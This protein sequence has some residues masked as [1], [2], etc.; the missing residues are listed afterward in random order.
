MTLTQRIIVAGPTLTTDDQAVRNARF[1][2]DLAKLP[3]VQ[4][5]AGSNNVPGIGYNFSAD[6][7]TRP[8]PAPGDE[9][10]QYKIFIA[11]PGFF[12]VYDIRLTQGRPFTAQEAESTW[13]NQHR[14]IVNEQA[15]RQLG[16]DPRQPVAGKTIKW[17]NTAFDIVGV[18]TDYH[19]LSKR[20]AIEPTI[21]L[22]SSGNGYFTLKA[23][24]QDMP[25]SIAQLES[26]FKKTF[27]GNPFD[28]DFADAVYER[29]FLVENRLGQVFVGASLIAILIACLGIFG[30]AAFAAQQRTKEIGVRKVLGA[31][32]LSIVGLLS[33]DFLKLVLI[34][35]LLASP[36]AWYAMNRW[37]QDFAYRVEVSWWVFALAGSLAVGIA[38]LTVSFQSIRAAL[39]NPVKSLRSE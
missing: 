13:N 7:I 29:Q 31:S 24:T 17:G 12:S 15:A 10:K 32:V 21:Y 26:L 27:P 18:V 20:Q 22:A 25:A 28:Y 35:I 39:V 16:Y 9:K 36:L 4:Q 1:K 38:L 14:V 8:T 30:L 34:A 5:V 37:L 6:G 19:H 11:D 3:F 33:K 2:Q 23:T